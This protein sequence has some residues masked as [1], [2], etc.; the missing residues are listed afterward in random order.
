MTFLDLDQRSSSQI[1]S[2]SGYLSVV[3]AGLRAAN[4]RFSREMAI[5]W[6]AAFPGDLSMSLAYAQALIGEERFIQALSILQSICML[7]VEFLEAAQEL[8]K[9]QE[10]LFRRG[11][12][13][14]GIVE[15]KKET[16]LPNSKAVFAPGTMVK[17]YHFAMTGEAQD[18][19]EIPSWATDLWLARQYL[20]QGHF[21]Q[22]EQMIRQ[23]LSLQAL[24]PLIAVT[25]LRYLAE[26]QA[27]HHLEARQKS[28]ARYSQ[29]WPDNLGCTLFHADWL[30][31]SGESTQ[32]VAMLHQAA[33]RD[34]GGQVPRRLWG[35]SHPYLPLWPEKMQ[36]EFGQSIPADVA[37][38]L[39][40]NQLPSQIDS[41]NHE[42]QS[43]SY[44]PLPW[45]DAAVFT[46]PELEV[47]EDYEPIDNS[48]QVSRLAEQ[49]IDPESD[50]EVVLEDVFPTRLEAEQVV[51]DQVEGQDNV[52]RSTEFKAE[53][54]DV[55][56][57]DGPGLVD[58]KAKPEDLQPLK[59]ELERLAKKLR[60]PGLTQQDGRFPVYLILSQKKNLDKIYGAEVSQLIIEEMEKLARAVMQR[61]RWNA[62]VFLAD[63]PESLANLGVHPV[64]SGTAWDI[65]LALADLD[66]ALSKR[67]EMVGAVLIVG[68]PEIVPFHSLPNPVDDQDDDVPSDNPYATRDENYFMPEW[69]VGRLPGGSGSD[70]SLLLG[71]LRRLVSYH[72][73][74][75]IRKPWY[76]R[77]LRWMFIDKN[78][79][80]SSFGYTAAVWRNAAENVFR[81]IGEPKNINSSPPLGLASLE[82]VTGKKNGKGKKIPAPKA[83]L[84]YFNLH[85]MENAAEWYG[86]RDPLD[87][88][89]NPDYPIALRPQ[90]INGNGRNAKKMP[91]VVFSEACYGLHIYGRGIEDAISL[92]F[93]EAGSLA[94]VGSTCMAYGSI[95]TPLV[96]AD[97]LGYAFWK[98]FQEGL[99]AGEA[100]R[101]AKVHLAKVMNNRQGYLDGEDQKTIISFV[102]YGDPLVSR[103][104]HLKQPKSIWRKNESLP[105]V[106]TVCDRKN[107][108]I[109]AQP[110]PSDVLDAV[111]QVV[112]QYLP[113]MSN[114]QM[115]YS[116]Q[117]R[118]CEGDGHS[119]PTSELNPM[120][121]PKNGLELS[122]EHKGSANADENSSTTIRR[123]VTLSKQIPNSHGVHAQV[124]RLTLDEKGK[125][126]KLVVSR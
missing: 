17:A 114:A 118:D 82:P 102:L 121:N 50:G 2:R 53:T 23:V 1:L 59:K 85:G 25:H 89:D 94:V 9:L 20:F 48:L 126:V 74:N 46:R 39:G 54:L 90:D 111:R 47:G 65:K 10:I 6:L 106:M 83:S 28:A 4:Y 109:E 81:P 22:A 7:D 57:E 68:G 37:Y 44:E 86:Q 112:S 55:E 69:P 108:T 79:K 97:L 92:K 3:R 43:L 12:V 49:K 27:V 113:G 58:P 32:A 119:C 93:L 8:Y 115:V 99:P 41:K 105:Q 103:E 72:Q 60:M 36:L 124:A 11:L 67:G 64:N 21:V 116:T 78:Q 5:S 107:E 73:K 117:R 122:S 26:N 14:P 87:P 18:E 120:H 19:K 38:I 101:Q 75:S 52:N 88:Q 77:F 123:L 98:F 84:A 110:I 61:K 62:R 76:R 45:D 80:K 33:A 51:S 30:L 40:W 104:T 66:K 42:R 35:D 91:Q 56:G 71:V 96:A 63:D 70:A 100:L 29:N 34:V 16:S 125:L 15:V 13:E 31:E 95:D 24:H